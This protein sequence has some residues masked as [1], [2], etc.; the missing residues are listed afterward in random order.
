MD[1]S[2]NGC[3][4]SGGDSSSNFKTGDKLT[5]DI[6]LGEVITIEASAHIVFIGADMQLGFQFDEIDIDSITSLRR[7]VE[8]NMGDSSMLER[9]L[10]SLSTMGSAE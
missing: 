8:L 2:L 10:H 4:V 5:I 9:D 1:I 6:I 3:L 7:L